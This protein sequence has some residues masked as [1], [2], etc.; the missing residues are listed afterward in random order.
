MEGLNSAGKLEQLKTMML[1]RNLDLLCMQETH[2]SGSDVY[3]SDGFLVVLSGGPNDKREYAGGGFLV[4]PW[5]RPALI[6]FTQLNSRLASI[7]FRVSGGQVVFIS[8]YAPH[9]GY[10]FDFR[11]SFFNDL[12]HF[13]RRQ[14]P[15][16]PTLVLGDLNSRLHV[17]RPGEED[18]LGPFVF[19]NKDFHEDPMANRGLLISTVRS[20]GLCVANTCFDK[21]AEQLVTYF[22]LAASPMD[23]IHHSKFAQ[24]DFVLVPTTWFPFVKDIWSDRLEALQ[25][26]HFPLFVSLN[27]EVPKIAKPRREPKLVISA[28]GGTE[29]AADFARSFVCSFSEARQQEMQSLDEV[30]ETISRA[31]DVAAN[32]VLPVKELVAHRPWI[33]SSTLDLIEQRN[34]A[35]A[36]GQH[37]SECELNRRIRGSARKDRKDW[38]MERLSTGSWSEVRKLRKGFEPNRGRLQNEEG[39]CVSSERRA[40]ALANYFATVQWQIRFADLPTNELE[41][42]AAQLPIN[43]GPFELEE[44]SAVLKQLK[45][46]KA[47]G[48]DG[49]PPDFWRALLQNEDAVNIL[50]G[51]CQACWEQK[52]VP[53]DWKTAKVV[54]LFKKGDDSLPANYRPISLLPVGYKVLAGMLLRRLQAGG[55]EQ[56]I[57]QSQYGFRPKR[58][59]TDAIFLARRLIDAAL[60]QKDGKLLL[61][62]LDWQKAF[63]RVKPAAL[64]IALSRF[65]V[66]PDFVN[67]VS[68]IYSSRAFI[69]RDSGVE[70]HPRTQQ[71]GIAQGCPL[72]PYLFVIVMSVLMQDVDQ[73]M[74]SIF[75]NAPS[76]PFL[77]SR[78]IL[79]ADDTLLLATDADTLQRHLEC[80]T[81]VGRR[82]GLELHWGKTEVLRV[83]HDGLIYAEG[84]QPLKNKDYAVYLGSLLQAAGDPKAEVDRRIGEARSTF[85]CLDK[86]WS[87]ANLSVRHKVRIFEAC[88]VSKLLCGL[89]SLWLRRAERRR[90]DG[91][92]ALWLRRILRIPHSYVSRVTNA[93][94]LRKAK[95]APLS[96]NL[97]GRQLK[98]FGRICRM[99]AS[100]LLR[101]AL[102]VPDSVD[103]RKWTSRRRRGRPRQMWSNCVHHH[104]LQ[105]A[106]LQGVPL[107][108]LVL[109]DAAYLTAVQKYTRFIN[110]ELP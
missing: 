57:R 58:G 79:Y 54:A 51:L 93:E 26:H 32:T 75:K 63:D 22:E 48:V 5:L 43:L 99:E 47:S 14:K 89:D 8:A 24:L 95:T 42:S 40:D 36:Y 60:D 98:L 100:S 44:I 21:A 109:D 86:I 80:I 15:H 34:R 30:A 45:R 46:G 27:L 82:Y 66:P 12:E 39:E 61:L 11:Q 107:K 62:M 13:Y 16:G 74:A 28:L 81:R 50:L 91:A 88:V 10:D 84:N 106:R 37:V 105:A 92:Q 53:Q 56:R 68:A 94:V 87:H 102:L 101:A 64:T 65:G 70:S 33:S 76:E 55:A 85:A 73:E 9:G 108:T 25:S 4:A 97:L 78:D 35:R 18:E 20:L 1:H 71:S 31:F 41:A 23:I 19:G 2:S 17:R 90:L 6:G 67:M 96:Q 110:S 38:L 52:A 7:K 49:I 77:V 3:F 59:T 104:A 83:R 29:T 72:S 69:V 103:I